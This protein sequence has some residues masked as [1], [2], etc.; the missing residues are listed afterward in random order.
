M[1]K[2]VELRGYPEPS[3]IGEAYNRFRK[4]YPDYLASTVVSW[5]IGHGSAVCNVCAIVFASQF[6]TLAAGWRGYW[7]LDGTK[8]LQVAVSNVAATYFETT[9]FAVALATPIHRQLAPWA[10]TATPQQFWLATA[11][12]GTVSWLLN[13]IPLSP[14]GLHRF[15]LFHLVDFVSGIAG[16]VFVHNNPDTDMPRVPRTGAAICAGAGCA[17]V[18]LW[19][20]AK[21]WQC[22]PVFAGAEAGA[23]VDADACTSRWVDLQQSRLTVFFLP[24]LLHYA[25]LD[26]Y[27]TTAPELER[28]GLQSHGWRTILWLFPTCQLT[29]LVWGLLFAPGTECIALFQA[30]LVA[31]VAGGLA[32]ERCMPRVAGGV[33]WAVEAGI[34]RYKERG[35]RAEDQAELATGPSPMS[36]TTSVASD[37]A[38][39]AK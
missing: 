6:C 5:I 16:A 35:A 2:S 27:A 29:L 23:P 14:V 4:I 9:L 10:G 12:G 39:E 21:F 32:A 37:A 17:L 34:A 13:C 28:F 25:E 20:A 18:A 3:S 30:L 8:P 24:V 26:L 7:M 15:L 31:G 11:A 1:P 36:E 22:A 33:L 38:G 19:T